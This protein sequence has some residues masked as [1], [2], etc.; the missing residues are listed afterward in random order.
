MITVPDCGLPNG[1]KLSNFMNYFFNVQR[2]KIEVDPLKKE[3]A[4]VKSSLAALQN[5][6]KEVSLQNDE[7]EQYSRRSCLRVSGIA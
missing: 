1:A 3:L 6:V 5:E 4:F 2:V 7:L